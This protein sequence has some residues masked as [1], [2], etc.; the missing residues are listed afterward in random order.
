MIDLSYGIEMWAEVSLILSQCTCFTDRE[1][2]SS[3]TVH[4]H[5]QSHGK[6]DNTV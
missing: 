3:S 4:M 5:L 2:F 1:S 6:M